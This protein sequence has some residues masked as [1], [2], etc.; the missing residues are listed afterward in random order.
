MGLGVEFQFLERHTKVTN[1]KHKAPSIP[2]KPL[3]ATL[4]WR[5]DWSGT[6]VVRCEPDGAFYPSQ[7]DGSTGHCWCV[8]ETGAM[9]PGTETP[10]GTPRIVCHGKSFSYLSSSNIYILFS[11]LLY[12]YLI[13]IR[14]CKMRGLHFAWAV[15]VCTRPRAHV[16]RYPVYN[17]HDASTRG[18]KLMTISRTQRGNDPG[19]PTAKQEGLLEI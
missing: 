2:T 17:D 1:S 15:L 10:P 3:A 13:S 16:S 9:I 4:S 7:C 6:W 14:V 5:V 12:Y 8:D 11:R 18:V 19:D